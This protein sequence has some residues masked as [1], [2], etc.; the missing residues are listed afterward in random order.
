MN[1]PREKILSVLALAARLI[2]G[3][4]FMAS[5]LIK[6]LE[7]AAN[8]RANLYQYEI[9]PVMLVPFLSAVIPWM[10]WI[11]GFFVLAGYALRWSSFA[12][13]AFSLSL[14]SVIALSGKLGLDA[15]HTCGCFGENGP[16]LTYPQIFSLDLLN[17]CF[18]F[19]LFTRK[20]SPFSLD[21]FLL[22]P[23]R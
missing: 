18:G 11:L 12:L 5:G 8:F 7:P 23:S 20:D 21:R 17:A 1:L 2:L 22:A 19:F 9:I 10:E 3:G 16:Q 13:G 4:V 14:A 6:L 15:S